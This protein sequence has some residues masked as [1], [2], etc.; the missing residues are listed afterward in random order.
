C[1]DR[2]YLQTD[3]V[4]R[5]AGIPRVLALGPSRLQDDVAAL[6][7]TQVAQ[8]LTEGLKAVLPKRVGRGARRYVTY[9]GRLAGLL[10]LGEQ[11]MRQAEHK[12]DREPDQPHGH[13]VGEGWRESSRRRRVARAGR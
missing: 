11:R 9:S 8:P 10:R 13:L 4:S 3:Q 5:E 6:D 1:H 2:S 12:N 7:I